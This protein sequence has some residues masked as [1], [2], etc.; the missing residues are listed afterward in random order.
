MQNNTQDPQ[1]YYRDPIA[2]AEAK[3]QLDA[4]IE[5]AKPEANVPP[6]LS[7][8]AEAPV[9]QPHHNETFGP[10]EE[11]TDVVVPDVIEE[12]RPVES[13][14][15]VPEVKAEE[16][17]PIEAEVVQPQPVADEAPV[18]V[19]AHS[20]ESAEVAQEKVAPTHEKPK[21]SARLEEYLQTTNELLEFTRKERNSLIIRIDE[22]E[23]KIT[24]DRHDYTT[25]LEKYN[26]IN[27]MRDELNSKNNLIRALIELIRSVD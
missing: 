11:K 23:D 10:A 20:E 8:D 22:E 12:V 1:A 19:E 17:K 24:H 15:V 5:E 25:G 7:A 9:E 26:A 2:E 6:M 4:G 13:E 14:T 21:R 27:Q 18:D 16:T 3:E